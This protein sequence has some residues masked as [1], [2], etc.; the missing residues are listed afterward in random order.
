M[1][2]KPLLWFEYSQIT[3]HL[4]RIHN[5]LPPVTLCFCCKSTE[6]S[7]VDQFKNYLPAQHIGKHKWSHNGSIA[8]Y[9][10]F[11]CVDVEF[12]PGYFFIGYRS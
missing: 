1:T 4:S 3:S 7:Y 5:T 9:H 2:Y 10:K 12:T 8:L 11:W 6:P